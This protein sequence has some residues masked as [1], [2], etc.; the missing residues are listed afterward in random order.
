MRPQLLYPL[1]LDLLGW[2][3]L[4]V[5]PALLTVNLISSWSIIINWDP[6][7]LWGQSVYHHIAI[8]NQRFLLG[9]SQGLSSSLCSLSI[10][11]MTEAYFWGWSL[12]WLHYYGWQWMHH[13][14]MWTELGQTTRTNLS[15]KVLISGGQIKFE[16]N[17]SRVFSNIEAI[18]FIV[19]SIKFK[20][21]E[22]QWPYF[23]VWIC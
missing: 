9:Q 7:G 11:P 4:I 8:P 18:L 15:A 20:I 13:W 19:H 16:L 22:R 21:F 23:Q 1:L 5:C 10:R 6:E 14:R 3:P 2:E 17:V 12:T